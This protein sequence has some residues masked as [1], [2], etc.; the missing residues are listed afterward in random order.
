MKNLFSPKTG[1]EKNALTDSDSV[2]L[3][4]IGQ[5]VA[6][7]PV[8]GTV[9]KNGIETGQT[10]VSDGDSIR[11][12]IVAANA[13]ATTSFGMLRLGTDDVLFAAV[14]KT[15]PVPTPI[16]NQPTP[17]PFDVTSY[18]N[19]LPYVPSNANNA[20]CVYNGGELTKK[21]AL[22]APQTNG[23]KTTD[24]IVIANYYTGVVYFL[25]NEYNM[26]AALNT[27][28]NSNPYGIACTQ[29]SPFDN[30]ALTWITL[31]GSNQVRVV[32]KNLAT[33]KTYNVGQR[34][35][36]IA[37]SPDHKNVYVAN[38]GADSVT[39]FQYANG[40]W[41][42]AT[43]AVGTKPFEIAVDANNA[44]WVTCADD[45]VYRVAKN[46]VVTAFTPGPTATGIRGISIAPDGT[47]W[48]AC[49]R[50]STVAQLDGAGS[51][52]Q[53]F[54]AN[55][56][57]YAINVDE[58][59]TVQLATFGA[60]R[61]ERY[62]SDGSTIDSVEIDRLPYGIASYGSDLLVADLWSN[63]PEYAVAKDQTPAN[64]QLD[65]PESLPKNEVYLSNAITIAGLNTST[66]ASVPEL[67]DAQIIK[68]GAGAGAQ[69]TVINGDVLRVEFKT[70]NS[71][72]VNIQ[73]PLFVGP[74]SNSIV[75]VTEI[76][77]QVPDAFGFDE[78]EVEADIDILSNIV[79]LSGT[80]PNALFPITSD[81]GSILINGVEFSGQAQAKSGDTL[82][83]KIRSS[84]TG[85]VT[86]SAVVVAGTGD[87]PVVAIW[88][89]KTRVATLELWI[90]PSY[91]GLDEFQPSYAPNSSMSGRF[92]TQILPTGVVTQF[93][94]SASIEAHSGALL[95][96]AYFDSVV[97][98]QAGGQFKQLAGFGGNRKPVDVA[99]NRYVAYAGEANRVYDAQLGRSVIVPGIPRKIAVD[100]SDGAIY[101]S[102]SNSSIAQVKN[103]PN[104]L[105]VTRTWNIP[106]GG[107]P[108]ALSIS[109]GILWFS[110]IRLN[111]IR[112]IDL[113]SGVLSSQS[114]PCGQG[115]WDMK[116]DGNTI[117]TA[118][119]YD[120]TF[121]LIDLETATVTA[122]KSGSVPSQIEILDGAIYVGCYASKNVLK[123]DMAGNLL[124]E[125][126][127]TVASPTYMT[128]ADGA[129][130]VTEL[131]ATLVDWQDK[132][133]P[134][135]PL[136]LNFPDEMD[137]VSNEFVFSAELTVTGLI[138]PTL[139]TV[140]PEGDELWVNGVRA[141]QINVARIDNGQKVKIRSMAP[142]GS[143]EDKISYLN[144][145]LSTNEFHIRTEADFKPD[146]VEF[147]DLY[148]AIPQVEVESQVVN[149]TGMSEGVQVRI[150]VNRVGWMV[151]INDGTPVAL[152]MVTNGDIVTIIGPSRASYTN[153]D[154][155]DSFS[156]YTLMSGRDYA[157]GTWTVHGR[158]IDGPER[159]FNWKRETA[160]DPE[161]YD[162]RRPHTLLENDSV[163]GTELVSKSRHESEAA[164]YALRV[165]ALHETADASGSEIRMKS[166]LSSG[167]VGHDLRTRGGRYDVLETGS[168]IRLRGHRDFAREVELL[169]HSAAKEVLTDT[170][171]RTVGH[172]EFSRDV[173]KFVLTHRDA[174]T[175]V[176]LAARSE[177]KSVAMLSEIGTRGHLQA[178]VAVFE[179][180][181]PLPL[182]GPDTEV[183]VISRAPM[184][185][186]PQE[187]ELIRAKQFVVNTTPELMP[188]S[189]VEPADMQYGLLSR[190]V[191]EQVVGY[192][193]E[194]TVHTYDY[195]EQPEVEGAW[196][197]A[198]EAIN[199]GV[200][201]GYG[202]AYAV[203]MRPGR[204]VYA[205]PVNDGDMCGI[206]FPG[207]NGTQDAATGYIHGG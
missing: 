203:E 31:S 66:P 207:D 101:V 75:T 200:L 136:V 64:F 153:P 23:P 127:L 3:S 131:F 172:H 195:F 97:Y 170:S 121:S 90:K 157:L 173:E 69:T 186:I 94:I 159:A 7:I 11:L 161:G 48:L 144:D 108:Y 145:P 88:N 18:P 96:P 160:T 129:I 184:E 174:S 125:I 33:V 180:R 124:L 68:N 20:L 13:Y 191:F 38:Y 142:A 193:R 140:L 60:S 100:E 70:P 205:T 155:L 55:I 10:T 149:I 61:I 171:V 15:D 82:Q 134:L 24:A 93:P 204:F 192:D 40:N 109:S 185:A 118:D 54:A 35:M 177:S 179:M 39:H 79:T 85:G 105:T 122:F 67:F 27:G 146:L 47:I 37:T 151:S 130:Y 154:T 21:V 77:D 74:V 103:G 156:R 201:A 56:Y 73:L 49:S 59:G 9:F 188:R 52:M 178:P 78:L 76:A 138:R 62:G 8:S 72:G 57:P 152:G 175:A 147:D 107:M 83:L 89:V 164:T 167:P 139:A 168:E 22:V 91:K 45:K 104:G 166:R 98:Q 148:G 117:W 4:G 133:S 30:D 36:G 181:R 126:L 189:V 114:I 187:F 106:G 135:L 43:V 81:A 50:S 128:K 28:S 32:N 16:T 25:D 112:H 183:V 44:A 197:S 199:A 51:L 46:N 165:S 162:L 113:V 102:M 202:Q 198:Q 95:V 19:G 182:D 12:R 71:Y 53:S 84:A 176:E 206:P 80:T 63:T 196:G 116:I 119:S 5:N 1:R 143:Y 190:P 87:D 137:V 120:N 41:S 26:L 14:T 132:V 163:F 111:T 99:L 2:T 65:D 42:A 92:I 58:E 86:L 158:D 17:L 6:L 194:Y 29:T 34:P 141:Q 150:Y 110:D 115:V 169:A 123:Y